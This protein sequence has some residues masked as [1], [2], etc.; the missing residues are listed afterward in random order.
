M[1][2]GFPA[3]QTEAAKPQASLDSWKPASVFAFVR[4]NHPQ[5]N[6]KP[7]TFDAAFLA[8]FTTGG[9]KLSIKGRITKFTI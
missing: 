5:R 6:L 7:R 3:K 2:T 1:K 8:N 9:K 4:T